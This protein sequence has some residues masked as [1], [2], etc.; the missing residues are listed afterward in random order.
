LCNLILNIFYED[1]T[2]FVAIIGKFFFLC[3]T[4]LVP[5]GSFETWP[6]SSKPDNWYQYF[7]GYVSKSAAAQNGSSS[8]NMMVA[9]QTTKSIIGKLL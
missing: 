9:L 5:N 4:N 6:V 7:S 2:T 1:K 8:I 3:A